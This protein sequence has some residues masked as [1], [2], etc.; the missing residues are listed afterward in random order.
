MQNY[1]ARRLPANAKG[2]QKALTQIT[3]PATD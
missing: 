2:Q 3:A 1:A